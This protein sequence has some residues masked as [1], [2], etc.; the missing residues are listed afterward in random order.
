MAEIGDY[1]M[2]L[3]LAVGLL[4]V[5]GFFGGILARSI[6]LPTISGYIIIGMFLSLFNIIPRNL[7]EGNLSI[8][9]EVS[10]GIIGYL[11][12]GTLNLEML[13]RFG[14][15]IV[16][17]TSTQLIGAW[18]FVTIIISFLAPFF[19]QLSKF[20]FKL[21]S[22]FIYLRYWFFHLFL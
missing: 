7:V 15:Q 18:V 3:V 11:V 17:I 9:V 6:K 2:N 12:G 20:Q 16:I 19:L 10:L 14:K 22:K 1:W 4:L 13:R 5:I 21:I 8:I